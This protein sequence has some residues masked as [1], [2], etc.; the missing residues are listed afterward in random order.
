MAY[1]G[2]QH[3]IQQLEDQIKRVAIDVDENKAHRLQLQHKIKS[4]IVI[5]AKL[6]P[7][8]QDAITNAKKLLQKQTRQKD[9][10]CTA[11]HH[12]LSHSLDHVG[13]LMDAIATLPDC[14]NYYEEVT[15]QWGQ[16]NQELIQY[17][18]L[19]TTA[20]DPE[21]VIRP[22][23]P[24][25]REEPAAWTTYIFLMKCLNTE[26]QHMH[27][28]ALAIQYGWGQVREYFEKLEDWTALHPDYR[29]NPPKLFRRTAPRGRGRG[30]GRPWVQNFRP[31]SRSSSGSRAS[32]RGRF[33][34]AVSPRGRGRP[35]P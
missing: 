2:L 31:G 14:D 26:V 15:D 16:Y 13:Q 11:T 33:S 12:Q 22:E 30:R 35:K 32:S 18:T 21:A 6:V 10:R 24:M 29:G 17:N 9:F 19:R 4:D 23:Q 5:P 8:T 1:A 7:P 3:R 25:L 28:L 27:T 34:R 20:R